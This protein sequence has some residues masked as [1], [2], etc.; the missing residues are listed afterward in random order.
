M[1]NYYLSGDMCSESSY[2]TELLTYS[3]NHAPLPNDDT[4]QVHRF[5]KYTYFRVYSHDTVRDI[6]LTSYVHKDD[7]TVRKLIVPYCAKR[8]IPI[9]RKCIKSLHS[10]TI[11]YTPELLEKLF[12]EFAD[13]FGPL[14]PARYSPRSLHI[15]RW[16]NMPYLTNPYPF[17]PDSSFHTSRGEIVR[18]KNECITANKLYEWHIPYKTEYPIQLQSGRII[19]ADFLILNPYTMKECYLEVFG[20][21]GDPGYALDKFNRINDMAQ[22]GINY[23]SNLITLFEYPGAPFSTDTLEMTL[24]SALTR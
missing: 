10:K 14:T 6:A 2:L 16:Q 9:L 1:Y 23:G 12:L 8:S 18:S 20:K 4:L 7:L 24:Q 17:D 19:Y 22:V 21:M 15:S 11:P 5:Q 13:L 3:T